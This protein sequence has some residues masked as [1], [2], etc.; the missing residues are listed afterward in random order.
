MVALA[1]TDARSSVGWAR[2]SSVS[3]GE[4][5]EEVVDDRDSVFELALWSPRAISGS[6]APN[7]S[8]VSV[9]IRG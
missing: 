4:V 3:V 9:S 6:A 8:W 2:R 5:D 7:S 1:I